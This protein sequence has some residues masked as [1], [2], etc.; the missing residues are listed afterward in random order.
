MKDT[1][2]Y[3]RDVATVADG[4]IPQTNI[5]R[6]DGKRARAAFGPEVGQSASTLSVV[7]GSAGLIPRVIKQIV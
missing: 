5:V 6:Q 2:I 7:A 3:L 4:S 1:I